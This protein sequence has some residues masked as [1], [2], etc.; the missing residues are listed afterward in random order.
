MLL[1]DSVLGRSGV[2]ELANQVDA[3]AVVLDAAL[4]SAGSVPGL[5]KSKMSALRV[6]SRR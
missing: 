5:A 1:D 3:D 6:K 2:D 4:V